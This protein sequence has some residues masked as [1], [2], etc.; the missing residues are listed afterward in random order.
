MSYRTEKFRRNELE[1]IQSSSAVVRILRKYDCLQRNDVKYEHANQRE[2]L[3]KL[4]RRND[5]N[6]QWYKTGAVGS[7]K[8]SFITPHSAIENR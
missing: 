1:V 2:C 7:I 6:L 8:K 5:C 3:S 4:L